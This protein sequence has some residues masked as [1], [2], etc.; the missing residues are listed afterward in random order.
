M[1][2]EEG[3]VMGFF[4]G[5]GFGA[6]FLG[7]MQA[8]IL[9][10]MRGGGELDVPEA[11]ASDEERTNAMP[12]EVDDHGSEREDEHVLLGALNVS[13][14]PVNR[15]G[16]DKSQSEQESGPERG[17]KQIASKEAGE[18]PASMPAQETRGVADTIENADHGQR[19]RAETVEE[20]S[21]ANE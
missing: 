6:D 7:G 2:V 19:E 16:K 4:V 14:E 18:A 11:P 3:V 21:S 8:K 10:G 12:G 20:T 1:R 13:E 15:G 5:V 9:N 17:R